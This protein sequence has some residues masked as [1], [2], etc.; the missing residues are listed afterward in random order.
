MDEAVNIVSP[1]ISMALAG[2][3][4]GEE[5]FKDQRSLLNNLLSISDPDLDRSLTWERIHYILGYVYHSLHGALSLNTEQ[6]DLAL[7]LARVKVQFYSKD[8]F[9]NV[10]EAPPFMGWSQLIGGNSCIEGWEYLASAYNRWEWLASIFPNEL[11]YR[12]SLVA[13][14]MTL[15]I[16]ELASVI[17]SGQQ[18]TLNEN[19]LKEFRVPVTFISEGRDI[20]QSAILLLQSKSESLTK[21]W[22]SLDVTRAEMEDSWKNWIYKCG[23]WLREVYGIGSYWEIHHERFFESF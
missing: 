14:Y 8:N 23:I 20:N 21:L 15:N 5:Y 19:S 11:E 18:T 1:L 16:H 13:Y 7:D 9:G 10:W 3:E 17:S 2:V 6:I 4:S 22:S 12:V